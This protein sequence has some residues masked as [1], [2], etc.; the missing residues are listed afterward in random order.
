MEETVLKFLFAAFKDEF[1]N[2]VKLVGNQIIV[3]LNDGKKVTITI[4]NI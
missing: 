4:K 3:W 1:K 2:K